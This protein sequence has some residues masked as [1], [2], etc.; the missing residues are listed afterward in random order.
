VLER[1]RGVLCVGDQAS[2]RLGA[3]AEVLEDLP[4]AVAGAHDPRVRAAR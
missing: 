1:E 4:V 2:A 3:P